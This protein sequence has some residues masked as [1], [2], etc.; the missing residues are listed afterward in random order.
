VE[1]RA[2]GPR[3]VLFDRD[4]T[5]VVD[6]P[7]NGDPERVVPIDGARSC[8]DRLRAAGMRIAVVTNQSGIGRGLIT[9]AQLDAVDARIET[10]LG[11]F[12]GWFVCTHAP[13]QN[14]DCRKPKPKLLLDAAR[15]FGS[16]PSQCVFVGDKDEDAEAARRAGMPM[17]RIDADHTLAHVCAKILDV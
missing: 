13:E 2:D 10:L 8:L 16:D 14:C 1:K 9:L 7:Y 12:D 4:G 3:A 6:V 15:V 11:P 17:L 5:L